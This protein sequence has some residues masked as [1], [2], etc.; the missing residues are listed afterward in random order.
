MP[1]T[2]HFGFRFRSLAM[3]KILYS[4]RSEKKPLP[5]ATTL[6]E[7]VRKLHSE[8]IIDPVAFAKTYEEWIRPMNQLRLG[9]FFS[10]NWNAKDF[11]FEEYYNKDSNLKLEMQQIDRNFIRIQFETQFAFPYRIDQQ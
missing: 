2:L 4:F 7:T 10:I 6:F 11:P 1:Y 5:N 9:H 3:V 8:F